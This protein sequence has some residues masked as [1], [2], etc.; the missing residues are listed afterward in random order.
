MKILFGIHGITHK[1]IAQSE[2]HAFQ[3]RGVETAVCIYGNWGTVSGLFNSF[4]LVIKNAKEIK[5]Q[6]AEQQ[7]DIIYLN[8][9]LDFKTVV[10]D[11][12]TI[13]ILRRASKKRK[14]VLKIHGSQNGILFSKT[15]LLKRYVFRKTDL[16]LVLSA[17]ER[18][19]YMKIGVQPNR[20]QVTANAIDK[21][22]YM[23]DPGFKKK[24]GIAASTSVL[25]FVGRFMHE[26]GILDLVEACRILK[27]A[28]ADFV[29]YC[30]GNGPLVPEVEKLIDSYGLKDN[31]KLMGHIPEN[32]T[33]YYYSNCDMLILPTYHSEGFPMAVF[34]AVG[35]GKPVI[36]TQIRAAADYMKA[37]ENCLWVEKQNPQQLSKQ[38]ATIMNDKQLQATM[39]EHNLALAEKFTDAKIVDN[40][41]EYLKHI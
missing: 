20:V 31:I 38:I 33:R 16:F 41:L 35:A 27:A 9:G 36:T 21:S 5:K 11:A 34:Q 17:E 22:L 29:L 14:I 32:D 28:S 1:E 23:P 2:I 40:V 10:R 30:L 8:T 13:F 15:N 25:L 39:R 26:K 4:K 6:A 12:T 19:S 3:N 24:T 37:Y 7:S 18:E